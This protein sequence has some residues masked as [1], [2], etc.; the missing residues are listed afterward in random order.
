MKLK[1]ILTFLLLLI[2]STNTSTTFANE[3]YKLWNSWERVA[4]LP[5]SKRDGVGVVHFKDEIWML[6][7]WTYGPLSNDIY[8]SSDGLNWVKV[9]NGTWQGRHGAGMVAFNDKLWVFSGDGYDDIWS[10]EDGIDWVMEVDHAPWGRRYTPYITVFNEKI[11]LMGGIS[12]WDIFGAYNPYTP[13]AYNDVWSSDDGVNWKMESA[14]APWGPRGIIHG[15]LIH[16][17]EMWILGGGNKQWNTP[18][19]MYN[20][21]WKTKNGIDWE[22]VAENALWTP[23]IHFTTISF[24]NKIWVID[25]TTSTESLTNKVWYSEDGIEWNLLESATSFPRTHASTAFVHDNALFISAGFDIDA[26][27]R[28]RPPQNQ[29]VENDSPITFSIGN[30]SNELNINLTSGLQPHFQVQDTSIAIIL[31][32]NL[33]KTKS[34]GKTKLLVSHPGDYGFYPLDTM[35]I[36][37]TV[38]LKQNIIAEVLPEAVVQDTFKINVL[39]DSGLPISILPNEFIEIIDENTVIPLVPGRIS[40]ELSQDGDESYAPWRSTID[41]MVVGQDAIPTL[42]QKQSIAN[43]ISSFSATYGDAIVNL[44]LESTSGL[45]LSFQIA[46]TTVA[47]LTSENKIEIRNAG[48]TKI[49]VSNE[50]NS[51]Y[52]PL[53][54]SAIELIVHKKG[55]YIAESITTVKSVYGNEP[56]KLAFTTNSGIPVSYNVVDTSVVEVIDGNKLLI[57]NAGTTELSIVNNGDNNYLPLEPTVIDVQIDK[58]QQW[59][60]AIFPLEFIAKDT[61]TINAYSESG[62]PIKILPAEGFIIIDDSNFIPIRQGQLKL[63]LEQAGNHNYKPLRKEYH[64]YVVSSKGFTVHPI[65]TNDL[66]NL[67]ISSHLGAIE[68]VLIHGLDGRLHKSLTVSESLFKYVVDVR[69]FEPGIYFLTIK[70]NNGEVKTTK[71]MKR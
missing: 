38:K 10:S 44:E 46:D 67:T 48:N 26:I 25:G 35:Y 11:W 59:I 29:L 19:D 49:F 5:F 9:G 54:T 63:T 7:G 15:S 71:I 62:L 13:V 16:N 52:Y 60:E 33:I 20:D 65:P 32:G 18:V 66:I 3:P 14:H 4:E 39:G 53:F 61:I 27:Y 40:L 24:D 41:F 43:E 12:F 22:L 64:I 28:Y 30:E 23:R 21:V 70:W 47:A 17:D 36:D 8:K 34:T 69:D 68:K 2:L 1:L 45:P 31:D 56:A 50:G 42:R 57:K 37:L 58:K 55:Q 6:G 51:E